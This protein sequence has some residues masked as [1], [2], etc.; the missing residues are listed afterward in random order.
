MTPIEI[1]I[2]AVFGL[3]VLVSYGLYLKNTVPNTNYFNNQYW[4]GMPEN[5]VKILTFFQI[6][7]V[8]G[9]IVAISSWIMNPPTKGIMSKYLFITLLFF[10]ISAALW[11]YAVNKDITWLVISSLIVT[12]ICSILMLAGSI[13]ENN[14]RIHIVLGL[15]FLCIVTVLGDGVLWNANYI[16]KSKTNYM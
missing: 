5:L 6:L 10:F 4:F 15:L 1:F 11:A 2:L 3:L 12:A 9:F 13:E 16:I 7:A 14:P 8:V